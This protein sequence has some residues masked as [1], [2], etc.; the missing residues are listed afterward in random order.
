MQPPSKWNATDLD[1]QTRPATAGAAAGAATAA[2]PP[3]CSGQRFELCSFLLRL[4]NLQM[5]NVEQLFSLCVFSRVS[6]FR[7]ASD[8]S[9]LAEAQIS[10]S[11]RIMD[12]KFDL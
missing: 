9:A 4:H 11:V 3:Y 1:M 10:K 12:D 5:L 2:T 7:F 6:P 8:Q